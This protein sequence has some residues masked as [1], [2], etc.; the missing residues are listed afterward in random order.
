M[1]SILDLWLPILLSSVGVFIVSSIVHMALPMHKSDYA[2]LEHEDQIL[3]SMRNI[4]VTQGEYMFPHADSMQEAYSPEMIEKFNR[5]PVGIMTIWPNGQMNM[6]KALGQW[7]GLIVVL[8]IF[9][10]YCA[11]MAFGTGASG[12]DVFRMTFMVAFTGYGTNSIQNS[13]WKGQRWSV[14][15]KFLFDGV[16]YATTTAVLFAWMW[17]AA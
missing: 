2:G 10:G 1:V 8:S 5:G 7:F 12:M 11:S 3:D 14:A 15:G 6:G 13:I 9:A 17:P 4:G 16:L